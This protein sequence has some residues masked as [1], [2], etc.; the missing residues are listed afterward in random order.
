[1]LFADVSSLPI[2]YHAVGNTIN[3]QQFNHLW[4]EAGSMSSGGSHNQLEVGRHSCQ[5]F[6]LPYP[7]YSNDQE[8]IGYVNIEISGTLFANRPYSWH[9]DNGME[10]LNLPT[11][12]QG[13]PV[14]RHNILL[15]TRQAGSF[16][17]QV[18]PEKSPIVGT[19]LA[20]TPAWLVFRLGDKSNRACGL[21]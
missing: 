8:P 12:N 11:L 9:G 7:S 18:A 15:F 14:Y 13:G 17:V 6:G 2:F 1:M 3:A 4:V 5:F 20:A 21:F 19:W 16:S 10:R